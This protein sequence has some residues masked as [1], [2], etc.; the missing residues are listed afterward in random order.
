MA[1]DRE[2]EVEDV[3]D[4]GAQS[5]PYCR[6]FSDPGDCDELCARC[7]VQ[8]RRHYNDPDACEEFVDEDE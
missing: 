5:G 8:C 6:H 1:D 7:H 2:D 3:D 4:E